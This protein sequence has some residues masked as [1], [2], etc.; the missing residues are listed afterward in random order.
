METTLAHERELISRVSVSVYVNPI[1]FGSPNYDLLNS[2]LQNNFDSQL[3]ILRL[4]NW[5]KSLPSVPNIPL[6]A[7]D[8]DNLY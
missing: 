2:I 1:E 5:I 3:R 8:R 7:I 6:S 4:R